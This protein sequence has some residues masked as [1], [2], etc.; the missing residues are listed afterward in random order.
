MNKLLVAL[1]LAVAGSAVASCG[2]AHVAYT[3]QSNPRLVWV[4]P[5]VWVVEDSP[6]PLYYVDG[7]YWRWYEGRW[8]RSP[9]FNDGFV[10][11]D[12]GYV[13]RVVI[14]IPPRTY[15][16][17]HAP[18]EARVRVIEREHRHTRPVIRDHRRRGR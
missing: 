5:G 11:I 9:Y 10:R 2:P 15:V 13:P 17:Y 6:W 12:V 18:R 16:R 7:Y 14:N 3:V 8:Y 4:S 1:A